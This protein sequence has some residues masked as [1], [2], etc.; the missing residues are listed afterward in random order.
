MFLTSNLCDM[1][2]PTFAKISI[3]SDIVREVIAEQEKY[4]PLE[5]VEI[6]MKPKVTSNNQALRCAGHLESCSLDIPCCDPY[7]CC[8]D[9]LPIRLKCC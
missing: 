4:S 5:N 7:Y 9:A 2:A 8:F 1:L 3:G 6:I